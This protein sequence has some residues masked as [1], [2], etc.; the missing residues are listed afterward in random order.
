MTGLKDHAKSF[1]DGIRRMT[2]MLSS[3]NQSQAA[4]YDLRGSQP[5]EKG[6]APEDARQGVD[7][8]NVVEKAATSKQKTA[9]VTKFVRSVAKN[10]T[11]SEVVFV[12]PEEAARI[13]RDCHFPRQRNIKPG[14]VAR[15]ADEM[16]S[17][18]FIPGT[19]IFMGVMPDGTPYALNGNHCLEAIVKCGIGQLLTITRHSVES[20][21]HAGEI[22]SVFDLQSRRSAGD[23]IRAFGID[24]IPNAKRLYAAMPIIKTRFILNHKGTHSRL[25]M[26]ELM[27]SYTK[28]ATAFDEAIKDSEYRS[29]FLRAGVLAVGLETFK[30]DPDAA[31]EFWKSSAQDEGLTTGM[32]E[33]ALLKFLRGTR[34]AGKS[35]QLEHVRASACAWNAK[36]RGE[37][38]EFLKPNGMKSFYLLGTRWKDGAAE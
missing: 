30:A 2:D 36:F 7:M 6:G 10:Q 12:T 38:P 23:S 5:K 34:I 31:M 1:N 9:G 24:K 22:Y 35:G 25:D 3:T 37:E 20:L 32:P 16:T 17:G 14:N 29:L 19:Q 33:K 8:L 11:T 21:D 15:L 4:N 13:R 27:Q 26:L 18:R 28:E